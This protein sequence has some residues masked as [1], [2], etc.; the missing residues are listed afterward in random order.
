MRTSVRRPPPRKT[1]PHPGSVMRHLN[2]APA[3]LIGVRQQGLPGLL[4]EAVLGGA[5][6]DAGAAD[7]APGDPQLPAQ[8]PCGL[9]GGVPAGDGPDP[10]K[11]PAPLSRP[12]TRRPIRRSALAMP[13]REPGKTGRETRFSPSP[14]KPTPKSTGALS[15]R[16]TGSG[17]SP[18]PQ[19]G[20]EP[21]RAPEAPP[22]Q[23][24]PSTRGN[25]PVFQPPAPRETRSSRKKALVHETGPVCETDPGRET[26]PVT[27]PVLGP[28]AIGLRSSFG[29]YGPV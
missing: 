28:S 18:P 2:T 21:T 6:Q 10:E 4:E 11:L 9:R 23:P 12:G 7:P 20:P 15:G 27:G 17:R 24:G 3:G 22:G 19:P 25:H 1:G 29:P 8:Y 16:G 26:L 14:P 13:S 5:W